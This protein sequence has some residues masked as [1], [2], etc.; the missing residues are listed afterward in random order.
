[1]SASTHA[2]LRDALSVYVGVSMAEAVLG[3]AVARTRV[4]LEQ[5]RESQQFDLRQGIER[6]LQL[7]LRDPVRRAE[8]VR[9]VDR[10]LRHESFTL[11]NLPSRTVAG[12]GAAQREQL[13]EGTGGTVIYIGTDADVLFA[14]STARSMCMVFGYSPAA[15]Q[16]VLFVVTQL[17]QCVRGCA[18]SVLRIGHQ[19]SRR[20]GVEMVGE[21][22]G[23]DVAAA[24]SNADVAKL[25]D[26]VEVLA[27]SSGSAR[28]RCVKFLG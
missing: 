14:R 11:R 8:C 28:I 22:V 15:T 18:P 25:M 26:E 20:P 5:I 6:A 27:D 10:I 16:A 7:C 2:Q 19:I 13:A 3:A 1:M 23:A 17:A 21:R 24:W 9:D 12:K 4:R